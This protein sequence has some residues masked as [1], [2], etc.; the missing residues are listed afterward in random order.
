MASMKVL[1]LCSE[2][3]DVGKFG[4]ALTRANSEVRLIALSSTGGSALRAVGLNVLS[5]NTF[6]RQAGVEGV[7][8]SS[9]AVVIDFF[10]KAIRNGSDLQPDV[11]VCNLREPWITD[12][13][14]AYHLARAELI[15]AAA[16]HGVI[17]VMDPIRYKEVSDCLSAADPIE[18]KQ[19]RRRL[20]RSA[21][22]AVTKHRKLRI[23]LI[24]D[25]IYGGQLASPPATPE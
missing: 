5:P 11:L 7:D 15:T 21:K 14:V 8:G 1:F 6:F 13:G 19:L 25:W 16:E 2:D 9:T 17:V 23:Q 12:A 22:R 3:G 20:A 4:E 10:T 24:Q 18:V